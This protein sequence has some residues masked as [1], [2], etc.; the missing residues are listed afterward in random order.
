[1]CWAMT[2]PRLTL[3]AHCVAGAVDVSPR[4]ATSPPS[5]NKAADRFIGGTRR[6]DALWHA[7]VRGPGAASVVVVSTHQRPEVSDSSVRLLSSAGHMIQQL[8]RGLGADS[9][10]ATGGPRRC[11]LRLAT[12]RLKCSC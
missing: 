9:G 10:Q 12:T 5:A 4:S 8:R 1:R 7:Y 11:L 3:A 6:G 2:R